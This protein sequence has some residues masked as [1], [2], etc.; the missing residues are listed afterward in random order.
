MSV[1]L[2][3]CS[4]PYE[5]DPH[6]A[7]GGFVLEARRERFVWH[8]KTGLYLSCDPEGLD[9]M[10]QVGT[11]VAEPKQNLWMLAQRFT[12]EQRV[13]NAR[14][15]YERAGM[16]P[17]EFAEMKVCAP[18]EYFPSRH[19]SSLTDLLRKGVAAFF[20]QCYWFELQARQEARGKK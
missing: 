7:N 18:E 9:L 6:V 20:P 19:N 17:V 11:G 15:L 16:T 4:K 14:L 1:V 8:P 5:L 2:Y 12:V 10:V 13:A 3:P